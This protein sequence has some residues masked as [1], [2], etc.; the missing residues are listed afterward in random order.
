MI[1]Q[2]ILT[3]GL[4]ACLFYVFSLGRS[5][6]LIRLGLF[7]VVLIGYLF[8]WIPDLTN[9][10]AGLVGIGRGADLI[11]Y[12]WIIVSLFLIMR[13]HIRLRE[14]SELITK[15]ARHYTLQEQAS[16]ADAVL[17]SASKG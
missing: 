11:M 7:T 12:L 3:I 15:M 4:S 8:V 17:D 5:L 13:L 10:L 16:A 14:Q 9:S 6:P 2:L 1:A